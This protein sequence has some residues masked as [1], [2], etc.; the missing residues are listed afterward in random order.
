[1]HSTSLDMPQ[2]N[3]MPAN[4]NKAN[5]FLKGDCAKAHQPQTIRGALHNETVITNRTFLMLAMLMGI[6]TIYEAEKRT[7]VRSILCKINNNI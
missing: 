6:K 2:A 1:M 3:S 5:Y 7:D 4:R